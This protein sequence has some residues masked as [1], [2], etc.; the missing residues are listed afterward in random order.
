MEHP[1]FPWEKHPCWFH[2]FF[3]GKI[4][5]K[6]LFEAVNS[7]GVFNNFFHLRTWKV[8]TLESF[9]GPL[10]IYIYRYIYI[11]IYK[12][13]PAVWWVYQPISPVDQ[14]VGNVLELCEP[15]GEFVALAAR[16]GNAAEAEAAR[17]P[18]CCRGKAIAIR[19]DWWFIPTKWYKIAKLGAV[20]ITIRWLFDEITI[21]IIIVKGLMN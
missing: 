10:Y 16:A 9:W 2:L 20:Y 8:P 12:Y 14:Q 15:L 3:F 21:I 6:N 11:E 4:Y 1:I 19:V 5:R 17:R 18:S 13:I 7:G